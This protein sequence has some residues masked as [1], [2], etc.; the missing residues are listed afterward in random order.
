MESL[1]EELIGGEG[2]NDEFKYG[3]YI[4]KFSNLFEE[5]GFEVFVFVQNRSWQSILF[6][7]VTNLQ[8]KVVLKA[9]LRN[10]SFS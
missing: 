8:E 10:S 5:E 2:V 1:E 4:E 3:K 7:L 9:V 6:L